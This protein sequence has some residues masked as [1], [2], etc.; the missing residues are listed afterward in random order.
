MCA[1]FNHGFEHEI[2]HVLGAGHGLGQGP[3]PGDGGASTDYAHGF[4][5]PVGLV[6]WET[7]MSIG[8]GGRPPCI[9]VPYFSNPRIKYSKFKLGKGIPMGTVGT[10]DNARVMNENAEKVAAYM[11][12]R[13]KFDDLLFQRNDGSVH[14]WSIQDGKQKSESVLLNT[15]P[16][17]SDWRMVGVGD[18]SGDGANDILWQ[19]KNGFLRYWT[20]EDGKR[21]GIVDF[22]SGLPFTEGWRAVGVGDLNGDGNDDILFQ[23]N[24]GLVR[25]W[26]IL[27]GKRIGE[28]DIRFASPIG[29][30]WKL[31][32]V[33]D[34]NGDGTDDIIWQNKLGMVDYSPI[35]N[36]KFFGVIRVPD[37]GLVGRVGPE[38]KLVGAGDLN[39]DGTDDIIWQHNNGTVHYWPIKNAKRQGG[40]NIGDASQ[41]GELKLIG[42]GDIGFNP[43]RN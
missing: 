13:R 28:V 26:P 42:V 17:G 39:G 32:G 15:E 1:I 34:L 35:K 24:N 5:S 25:Y 16:V 7:I 14:Y 27:R 29:L 36:T 2:G 18:L 38:W 20:I 19:N 30:T 6:R 3:G 43:T 37:F 4:I 11:P 41:V 22:G 8:C 40:F 21:T 9:T 10:H 33:G 12:S 31:V 23:R